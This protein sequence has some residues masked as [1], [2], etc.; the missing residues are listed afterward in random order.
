MASSSFVSLTHRLSSDSNTGIV[1]PITECGPLA[2]VA[3]A[4]PSTS[5]ESYLS[6]VEYKCDEGYRHTGGA[7]SRTCQVDKRCSATVAQ[8]VP[9]TVHR[10]PNG[11][12]HLE[13]TCIDTGNWTLTNE[14]CEVVNCGKPP[15]L[16]NASVSFNETTYGESA[17]YTCEGGLWFGREQRDTVT[18]CVDS[19][20]WNKTEDACKVIDC[21]SP[22]NLTNAEVEFK[23]TTFEDTA[24]Y[25][26]EVG[27]RFPSG[28]RHLETSCIDTGNW[29]LT[30]E[31][32]EG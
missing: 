28:S 7:L 16:V 14:T 32:C 25:T 17:T 10:F 22:V 29:T 3:H 1:H 24:N 4:N 12:R 15:D 11:S 26:C 20:N 18:R 8:T 13:T 19:G 23:A 30:N 2:P 6:V 9:V 31:T 27:Y 5:G 21:G